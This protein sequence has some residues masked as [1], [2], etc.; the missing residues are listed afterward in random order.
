[1]VFCNKNDD[2]DN[3]DGMFVTILILIDG[4]LQYEEGNVCNVT[5]KVTILILIDGFL[6]WKLCFCLC[7]SKKCHNPYFNRWFSAIY[8]DIKTFTKLW[9]HNPY[10]NRWFSAIIINQTLIADNTA[11][12]S[13]F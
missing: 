11:S 7:I 10:F 5:Y 4:F 12:Q 6:Q 9:G 1:M 3:F 13:L 8:S 2:I